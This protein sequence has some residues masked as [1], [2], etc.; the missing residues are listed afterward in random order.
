MEQDRT[1]EDQ[2]KSLE[3]LEKNKEKVDTRL[4]TAKIALQNQEQRAR[5]ELQQAQRLLHSQ[6]SAMAEVTQREKKVLNSDY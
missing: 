3:K 1:I 5:D 4:A 6:A 2:S